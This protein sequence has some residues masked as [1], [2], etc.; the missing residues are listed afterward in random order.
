MD[1]LDVREITERVEE[2]ENT[3]VPVEESDG[4]DNEEREELA[5]LVSLLDDLKG[6]GGDHKWRGDW[7]PLTLISDDD[8]EDYAR[9][10][11]EDIDAIKDD[12]GWPYSC[13][14]WERAARELRQDYS[15]IVHD[16]TEDR[17]R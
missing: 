15:V 11:A 8:F 3:L 17:Y 13:I 5:K 4:S 12:V 2:L 9:Q 14:D 16:G 10:L 6:Y 7:Y 1:I